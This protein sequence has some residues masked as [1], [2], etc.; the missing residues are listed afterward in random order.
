MD[1][2][3]ISKFTNSHCHQQ[4]DRPHRN[5]CQ[6]SRTCFPKWKAP[7]RWIRFRVL[8][9]GYVLLFMTF[10]SCMPTLANYLP[11]HIPVSLLAF[12]SFAYWC[13]GAKYTWSY[14]LHT[15]S[16]WFLLDRVPVLNASHF[17]TEDWV[18]V[19]NFGLVQVNAITIDGVT[20][21]FNACSQGSASC[22]EL[23]LEYG[24]KPQ[25]ESCLPSPTH[26][27]ASKGNIVIGVSDKGTMFL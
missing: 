18:S 22:A 16:Q 8:D 12:K 25:L 5:S 13:V 21:L 2:Q 9:S 23:L 24:A 15:F 19:S 20:P 10:T 11:H 1:S 17:M 3:R 4:D 6:H 7:N 26:E 14:L 27:A